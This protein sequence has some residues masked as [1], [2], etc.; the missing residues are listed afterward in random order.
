MFFHRDVFRFSE[1]QEEMFKLFMSVLTVAFVI[2]AS[3]VFADTTITCQKLRLNPDG[4]TYNDGTGP[5]VVQALG[6]GK[7]NLKT[8][9]VDLPVNLV[10]TNPAVF[11]THY[12]FGWG[13]YLDLTATIDSSQHKGTYKSIEFHKMAGVASEADY[14][15]VQCE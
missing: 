1:E 13:N 15:M 5:L 7:Y 8:F 14:L 9:N 4:T 6:N 10:S 3:T 2:S 12:K 11:H